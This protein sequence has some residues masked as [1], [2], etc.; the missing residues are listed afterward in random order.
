MFA[1]MQKQLETHL[2][3]RG[4]ILGPAG[5][6]SLAVARGRGRV[7]WIED[8]KGIFQERV[9]ERTF[10]LLQTQRNLLSRETLS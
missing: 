8:K 5:F 1:M 6:E 3:V 9:N 7:D 10:G 4:I 2:R